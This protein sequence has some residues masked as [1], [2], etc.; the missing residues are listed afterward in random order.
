VALTFGSYATD[1][2]EPCQVRNEAALR[3]TICVT[4]GNPDWVNYRGN[5]R[6]I[7]TKRNARSKEYNCRPERDGFF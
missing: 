6:G 2:F 5:V 3:K 1:T 7:C 4:W